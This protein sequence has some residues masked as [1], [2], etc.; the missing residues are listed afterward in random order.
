MTGHLL[1]SIR[2]WTS[3][4]KDWYSQLKTLS[5]LVA[6]FYITLI[7]HDWNK[8]PRHTF[9]AAKPF[10]W[11][12]TELG[13]HRPKTRNRTIVRPSRVSFF[14]HFFFAINT[15]FFPLLHSPTDPSKTA[16]LWFCSAP[17]VTF[18][19]SPSKLIFLGG[20]GGTKQNKYLPGSNWSA[21]KRGKRARRTTCQAQ[22]KGQPR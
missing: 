21:A 15:F 6:Q 7:I 8:I 19:A 14:T 17:L 1:I 2:R 5:L 12:I 13:K 16:R 3:T 11:V 18:T 10:I 4:K 22:L 20:G 9:S